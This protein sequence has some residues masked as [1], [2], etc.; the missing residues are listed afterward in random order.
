[1]HL[2]SCL[3]FF[4]AP[5]ALH[6]NNFIFF[7]F[8]LCP[9]VWDLEFQG[10]TKGTYSPSGL[11]WDSLVLF[12]F[13]SWLPSLV[14][15][16]WHLAVSLWWQ[17]RTQHCLTNDSLTNWDV[18]SNN[19]SEMTLNLLLH[20]WSYGKC[21]AL[22]GKTVKYLVVVFLVL[23]KHIPIK[24]EEDSNEEFCVCFSDPG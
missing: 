23:C 1:M 13:S 19:D 15:S 8:L 20:L 22:R 14:R 11:S 4:S 5:L 10:H 21:S 12:A 2:L 18:V 3:F 7:H 17:R 9:W 24:K 6:T 16:P